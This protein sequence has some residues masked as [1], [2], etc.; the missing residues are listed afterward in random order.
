VATDRYVAEFQATN[1]ETN[2]HMDSIIAYM[3]QQGLNS[4]QMCCA[5][6]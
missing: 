1:E 6:V 3:Q 5:L 2:E 4:H